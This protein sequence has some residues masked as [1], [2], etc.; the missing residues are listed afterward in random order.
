MS[1]YVEGKELSLPVRPDGIFAFQNDKGNK[2]LCLLETDRT[3]MQVDV[4]RPITTR[5]VERTS[6][7]KK[8]VAYWQALDIDA[9]KPTLTIQRKLEYVKGK[10]SFKPLTTK[11]SYKTIKLPEHLVRLLLEYK[12]KQLL[13]CELIFYTI[14][15]TPINLYNLTQRHFHPVLERAGLGQVV[16]NENGIKSFETKFRFYDLRHTYATLLLKAGV[17]LSLCRST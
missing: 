10:L 17:H 8:L 16:D 2:V 1:L 11:S 3:T 14:K 5:S 12:D 9:M 6:V 13:V 4:S 15:G 7:F